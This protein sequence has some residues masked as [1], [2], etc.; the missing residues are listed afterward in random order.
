ML[1]EKAKNSMEVPRPTVRIG[2]VIFRVNPNDPGIETTVSELNQLIW[3][4]QSGY[5]IPLSII[6]KLQFAGESILCQCSNAIEGVSLN[7]LF[8]KAPDLV[9]YVLK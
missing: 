2:N 9:A 5:I 4:N 8:G 1:Q 7:E 6:V 3:G